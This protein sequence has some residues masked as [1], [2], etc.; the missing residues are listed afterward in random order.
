MKSKIII[1]VSLVFTLFILSWITYRC[2]FHY[3]ILSVSVG[4]DIKHK[5]GRFAVFPG[6]CL[7][8]PFK[9]KTISE[10]IMKYAQLIQE[11]NRDL[12]KINGILVIDR[13]KL[14]M[15]KIAKNGFEYKSM[16]EKENKAHILIRPKSSHFEV[17]VVVDMSTDKVI[18]FY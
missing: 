8:N 10:E 9:E 2:S 7:L 6:L 15:K 3:S 4:G 1:I 16:F 5:H 12:T 13:V 18:E 17:V 11:A 14:E